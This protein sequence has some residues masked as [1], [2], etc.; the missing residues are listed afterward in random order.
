LREV[1]RHWRQPDCRGY[2]EK[3]LYDN[4]EGRRMGFP[5]AAYGEILLLLQILDAPPPID[6][7]S[8]LVNDGKLDRVL[9]PSPA[10]TLPGHP[11]P[12]RSGRAARTEAAATAPAP[13]QRPVDL[14]PVRNDA[15][16][17]PAKK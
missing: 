12:A 16:P 5:L 17:E 6:I 10:S 9:K 4:R 14:E 3:L 8:D 7:D 13:S 1:T 15:R 11:P 2:L